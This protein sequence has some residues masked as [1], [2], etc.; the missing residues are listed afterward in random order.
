ML[1]PDD[2]PVTHDVH[3][4]TGTSL[5][6]GTMATVLGNAVVATCQI[7]RANVCEWMDGIYLLIDSMRNP[8]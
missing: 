4:R 1:S 2:E 6:H 5:V 3:S 7:G 8:R